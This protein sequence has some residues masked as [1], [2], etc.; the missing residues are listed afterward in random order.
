MNDLERLDAIGDV[1]GLRSFVWEYASRNP[2]SYP[3]R[4][5]S[6]P[7]EILVSEVMLQQTRTSRVESKYSSF[8]S[9]YPVPLAL[10]ESSVEEL[11]GLWKGLGYNR[12]G[13]NLKRCAEAIVESHTGRVPN[14][15][16]A[17]EA[18]PGIGPYTASAVRAFAFSEPVVLIETNIRRLFLYL[19]FKDR[20]DVDDR[21]ILVFIER[22]LDGS[23]PKAWYAALMDLGSDLSRW[24]ENPNR[25][26]RHYARQAR[27]EGSN[28]QI[29]GLILKMLLAG[30]KERAEFTSLPF[31]KARIE[32]QL[33]A[34]EREGFLEERGALYKLR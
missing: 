10:A 23:D 7:W 4:S 5:T 26:S 29:R 13:L 11:L 8:L 17:L 34:L 33:E 6:D 24:V 9:R 19:F 16:K 12:R 2:R 32:T 20:E 1:E 15:Q 21:E 3:W 27:F 18:L 14:D 31:E 25:K 28:R 30:P 22:A